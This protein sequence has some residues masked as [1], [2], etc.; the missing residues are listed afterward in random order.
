MF[1]ENFDSCPLSGLFYGG[2]AGKKIGVLIDDE[3]WILKFPRP[4]RELVGNHVP[5]YTSSP[6]SEWLGSHIYASLGIP[7]HE[8]ML[9]WRDGHIVCACKD[10]TWPDK[11]LIEFSKLKTTMDDDQPGFASPPSDGSSLYL[12]DVLSTISQVPWLRDDPAV[13]ERF[14]RMFVVDALIKNPDRNN[15]NWGLLRDPAGEFSLAPVYDCGS[16]LYAKRS[17]SLTSLRMGNETQIEEDAISNTLSCYQVAGEDG[18]G[19][20][21]NPFDYM[22]R[23][24]DPDLLDAVR[25]VVERLDLDAIADLIDSIPYEYKGRVLMP[26][27]TAESHLLLM[28]RRLEEGLVPVALR[29]A[30]VSLK[31]AA[32]AA[33]AVSD[34]PCH[35]V[36]ETPHPQRSH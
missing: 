34:Q 33:R 30:Q 36:G 19:H 24:S 29:S 5:S 1:I 25:W 3:P 28:D 31:A 15:G 11:T 14:W 23:S 6:V 17:A 9:G 26:P 18:R 12:S 20:R 10:F 35:R 13:L 4:G 21:I 7:A 27:R 2:R 22:A 32:S 16:S 8:T